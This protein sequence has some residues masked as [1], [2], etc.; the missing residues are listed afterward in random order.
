MTGSL[1]VKGNIY[2]AVLNFKDKTGKRKQKW[3]NTKLPVKGNKR[4]AEQML[5]D[6]L[7]QYADTEYTEPSKV[8]FCDFV[9]EWIQ[10]D[11][12]KLQVTTYD[13]YVHILDRHLY[14]YFQECGILLTKLQPIDLQRYYAEKSK[15]LSPNTVIKHHAII[16]SALAYAVKTK[17]LPENVADL[18][19]KP[20]REK[21]RASC[22][23]LPELNALLQAARGYPI[24]TP[25]VLAAYYGLRRS[26]VLGLTWSAINWDNNTLSVKCKVVRGHNDTGKLVTMP[27]D[28][29]KS[30]SSY[31]TLPLCKPVRDYLLHI[32]EQQEQYKRDMGSEYDHRFDGYICVNP[33][34]QLINPDYVTDMFPK[35]LQKNHLPHIRFHD[36]RHSCATLLVNLGFNLKDVQEWLGHSDFL[37]TA[38][39]Y[40]HVDMREKIR[41]VDDL[42]G[43]LNI[44]GR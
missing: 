23:D 7:A 43:H 9:K 4:K 32:R 6:W 42:S 40:T 30:E 41:M 37:I 31:R 34:G 38:N 15:T 26:E 14:P 1:Q 24:E 29:L 17:M 35:L 2:Y 28:K 22:Y 12:P 10:L 25:I 18:V 11:K 21:Y 19:D 16:R 3:F 44:T 5:N 20:K 33:Q 8:L 27:Q 13:N 36:L 39:T